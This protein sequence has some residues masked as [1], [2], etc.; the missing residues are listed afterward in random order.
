MASNQRS[1]SD[2]APLSLPLPFFFLLLPATCSLLW[3]GLG[4]L[5][6]LAFKR[7]GDDFSGALAGDLTDILLG[8]HKLKEEIH[9]E[10]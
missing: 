7:L 8:L 9:Y 4:T 3:P 2:E 6:L 1:S 5:T 10:C